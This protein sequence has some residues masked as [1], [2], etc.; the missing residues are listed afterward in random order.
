MSMTIQ[1]AIKQLDGAEV[2]LLNRKDFA[3]NEAIIVAITALREKAERED[4]K[5]LT[6]EELRQMDGEP[7]WVANLRTPDQSEYCVIFFDTESYKI[8]GD[9]FGTAAIPGIENTWYPFKTYEKE[10]LA[11]RHKPKEV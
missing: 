8:Y 2:L 9:K 3:F 1:E 11:Y 4:P 5:P 7:V 6:I 10:W